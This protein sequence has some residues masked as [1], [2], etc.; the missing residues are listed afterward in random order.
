LHINPFTRSVT[1]DNHTPVHLSAKEFDL[2]YF[3]FTHKGIVFTQEQLYANVWGYE[4]LSHGSNLTSFIR[5]LR[6]KI[7]P[8]PENPQYIITVWGVGYKFNEKKP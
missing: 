8:I 1:I 5:K 2:L 7:E 6:I 4:Y 3:L